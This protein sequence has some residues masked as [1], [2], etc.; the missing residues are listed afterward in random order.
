MKTTFAIAAALIA[1]LTSMPAAAATLIPGPALPEAVTAHGCANCHTLNAR[2]AGP[3]F[4]EIAA[5]YRDNMTA[6]EDLTAK[7]KIGSGHPK[8]DAARDDIRGAVEWI[9]KQK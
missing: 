3:S 1:G 2:K 8:V 9:L 6:A 5:K 7:V 4:R